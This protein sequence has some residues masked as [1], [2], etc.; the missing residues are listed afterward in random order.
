MYE[1]EF[2][3][4]YYDMPSRDARMW[5][6]IC[7][8][9]A[10]SGLIGVPF[11][12]ILG[13]LIVWLMKRDESRFIDAHGREAL[14]FQTSMTIYGIIAGILCVILI[15]IPILLGLIIANLV[16][17]IVA[18]V[19]ANDGDYYRYPITIRFLT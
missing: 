16:F 10:L 17:V 1:E 8:L 7:H 6:M 15:G 19:K 3:E 13:P 18:A 14:N 12:H 4:A 5:A 11:G 9:S 2:D